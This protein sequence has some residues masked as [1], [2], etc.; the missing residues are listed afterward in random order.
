MKSLICFLFLSLNCLG[1]EM[2]DLFFRE[3][4]ADVKT[5]TEIGY[6][7]YQDNHIEERAKTEYAYN[8]KGSQSFVKYYNSITN[9]KIYSTLTTLFDVNDNPIKKV[10]YQNDTLLKNKITYEYNKTNKVTFEN[11]YS[12]NGMVSETYEFVYDSLG[13][14]KEKIVYSYGKY[15]LKNVYHYDEKNRKILT[16]VYNQ[17]LDIISKYGIVY[18]NNLIIE[19]NSWSINNPKYIKKSINTYDYNKHLLKSVE[20]EN[21]FVLYEID[22]KHD[23]KGN[24][25]SYTVNYPN[26]VKNTT[27]KK[28]DHNNNCTEV[29]EMVNDEVKTNYYYTYEYDSK[30]NWIEKTESDKK[31]DPNPWRTK[32]I[33]S[34]YN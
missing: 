9:K 4:K 26:G 11:H 21:T 7:K 8:R 17:K 16:E 32:R 25:L 27:L 6:Y 31:D 18:K 29:I 15:V 14:L 2:T 3:L 1:Q 5:M 22:Y 28:F 13:T 34:Y 19:R 23:A 20:Y 30:N 24:Q 10:A 33:I 12:K